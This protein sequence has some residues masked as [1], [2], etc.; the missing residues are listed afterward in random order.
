M[1]YG[2]GGQGIFPFGERSFGKDG[3]VI[4]K[5]SL[6]LGRCLLPDLGKFWQILWP[7]IGFPQSLSFSNL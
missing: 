2:Q 7:V 5:T 1:G 4:V 3:L 6:G